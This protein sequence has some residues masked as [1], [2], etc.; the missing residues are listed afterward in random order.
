[1]SFINILLRHF[2]IQF[3]LGAWTA[4]A[5]GREASA[6]E[7]CWPRPSSV[8][9]GDRVDPCGSSE[10]QL[11][12]TD[13]GRWF[14]VLLYRYLGFYFILFTYLYTAPLTVKTNQRRPPVR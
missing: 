4:A 8:F 10:T 12:I 13:P 5:V 11:L 1:M 6:G 9:R 7:R 3:Q 2:E 14:V